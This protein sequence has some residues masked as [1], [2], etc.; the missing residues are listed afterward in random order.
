MTS[1][2][3][4]LPWWLWLVL[5]LVVAALVIV[6]RKAAAKAAHRRGQEALAVR[7]DAMHEGART[8]HEGGA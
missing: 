2:I 8:R 4:A 1:S 3:L 6:A 7:A 5:V